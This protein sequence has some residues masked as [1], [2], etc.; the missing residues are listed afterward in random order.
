MGWIGVQTL[1]QSERAL[2][3][4][5]VFHGKKGG[6]PMNG[7]CSTAGCNSPERLPDT[8]RLERQ[9]KEIDWKK[10]ETEV[11]RLQAR[12]AKATQEKKW[13]TVKR[14]QY[15]LT[16]S[17][18]ARALAVRKVTINRGK[19]TPGIDKE[20]WNTPAVKMHNG[21]TLTDKGYKAKPLRRVFHREIR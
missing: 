21:L 9:W 5:M 12:I 14:L 17:Y 13:N 6:K 10:A 1:P 8:G 18:Y 2:T 20:L 11:N 7:N 15:L 4:P 16:H 3:Y 19:N